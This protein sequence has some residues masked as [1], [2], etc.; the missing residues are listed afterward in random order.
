[1]IQTRNQ[2]YSWLRIVV[3]LF[4]L[5]FCYDIQKLLLTKGLKLGVLQ[6]GDWPLGANP[7]LPEVMPPLAPVHT[8][9]VSSAK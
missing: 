3:L 7:P 9:V 2:K 1:M 8:G 5:P 4:L 6:F